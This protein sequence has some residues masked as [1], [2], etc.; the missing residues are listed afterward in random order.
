MGD[1]NATKNGIRNVS[2]VKTCIFDENIHGLIV[3]IPAN[4]LYSLV[5]FNISCSI[6]FIICSSFQA[7]LFFVSYL[8]DI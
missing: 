1:R 3:E 2:P 7:P 8:E 6:K 4:V 5:E